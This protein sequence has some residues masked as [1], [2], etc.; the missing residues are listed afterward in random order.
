MMVNR[1]HLVYHQLVEDLENYGNLSGGPGLCLS[2]SLAVNLLY[3]R[4]CSQET[5]YIRS[6]TS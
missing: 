2:V 4:V 6:P 5:S 3:S 1:Y